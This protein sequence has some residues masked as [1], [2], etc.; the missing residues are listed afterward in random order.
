M[1]SSLFSNSHQVNQSIG[2]KDQNTA[3]QGTIAAEKMKPL[4]DMYKMFNTSS[5]PLQLLQNAAVNNTQFKEIFN[6]VNSYGDPHRAFLEEAKRRGLSDQDISN[7]LSQ[8]ESLL[9]VRRP[10]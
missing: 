7:G 8:M 9:G 5:N 4:V 1:S 3:N 2:L 6:Q 10:Q